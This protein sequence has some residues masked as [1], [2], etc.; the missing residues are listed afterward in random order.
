MH[1][2]DQF[3]I[4]YLL[5]VWLVSALAGAS[6]CIRNGDFE[7][8]SHLFAVAGFSGFVGFGVVCLCIGD[9]NAAVVNKPVYLGISAIVGLAGKEQTM[10]ISM[11]WKRIF[12]NVVETKE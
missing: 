6:R 9:L 5:V 2:V 10:I 12:G 7:S 11:L 8:L 3:S 1:D 4:L